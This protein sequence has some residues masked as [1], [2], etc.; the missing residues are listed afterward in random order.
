MVHNTF[1]L[2]SKVAY[3]FLIF[4]CLFY[5]DIV[6]GLVHLHDIGIVHR[7]LKPQNVLIVK[8]SSLCAKLSDMGI[9]KRLPADTS[10]LTRNSTGKNLENLHDTI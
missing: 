5:R 7:D 10:A 3:I 9:S 1:T 8:N 6:A 2:K 4:A